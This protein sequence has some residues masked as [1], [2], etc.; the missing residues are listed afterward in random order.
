V[1][2][3]THFAPRKL[4][5]KI[6]CKFPPVSVE[7]A[8]KILILHPGFTSVLTDGATENALERL[9]QIENQAEQLS[10]EFTVIEGWAQKK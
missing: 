7:T 1:K 10:S 5:E 8:R 3:F 2:D 4:R 6:D 9:S